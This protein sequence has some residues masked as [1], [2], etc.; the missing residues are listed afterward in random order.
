MEHAKNLPNI[1]F[2]D[3]KFCMVYGVAQVTREVAL[4]QMEILKA[5]NWAYL[6]PLSP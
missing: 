1:K 6:D 2:L 5:N 3:K 4:L